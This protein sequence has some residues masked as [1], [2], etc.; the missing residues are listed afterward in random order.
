MPGRPE[1]AAFLAWYEASGDVPLPVL[2][3]FVRM[4][5]ETGVIGGC[6]FLLWHLRILK[7][8]WFTARSMVGARDKLFGTGLFVAC[9]TVVLAYF[10]ESG[11]DKRYWPFVL[12]VAVAWARIRSSNRPGTITAE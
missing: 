6:F 4:F 7:L 2:N 10:G 5:A 3:L 9:A 8:V 11:F 1:T 12:G